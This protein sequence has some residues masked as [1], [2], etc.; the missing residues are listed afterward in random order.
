MCPSQGHSGSSATGHVSD[1]GGPA[2][3]GPGIR[4]DLHPRPPQQVVY[5]FTT[6]LANSAAEAVMHG[7]TDS[8]LLYH[9]QNVPRTKLDQSS[10]IGKLSNLTEQISSSHSPPIGTPKSQS[11]TPRPPSV[12]GVVGGHLPGTSTP[13]STGHPDGEPAQTL[14]GG[15]S[16][17]HSL[18]Q[19]SSGPQSVGVSGPDG[20]DRPGTIAHH[21]AG[22]SPSLSPSAL[23]VLRQSELGQRG[24][25]GNTDGLSKEQLEHRERSLQTLRDI[26]RLLLH[27]GAGAGHEEPR[28]P[29]GNPNGTNVNN[30]NSNDGGRGLEDGENGGGNTG[31]CHSN[32][33][34]IPGMPPVGGMK[35]YEDD[36]LRMQVN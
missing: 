15:G 8:I 17:V 13:S 11:G 1:P 32:N 33:A 35:K 36:R 31:N 9:Q 19:G 25:P 4:T 18:G 20:V 24:G 7:H 29:N 34:G 28:G 12:G 6:S 30:N 26:E 14:R 10:G 21:G 16:A 27:T 5:V 3:G 22:V 23:S 2:L